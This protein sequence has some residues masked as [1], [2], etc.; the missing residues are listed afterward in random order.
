VLVQEAAQF[1]FLH[2]AFEGLSRG[3]VSMSPPLSSAHRQKRRLVALV[4]HHGI[5]SAVAFCKSQIEKE[6]NAILKRTKVKFYL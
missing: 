1:V 6:F 5:L 4:D 2:L 3:G